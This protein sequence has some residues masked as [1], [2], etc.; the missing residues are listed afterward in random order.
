MAIKTRLG[1]LRYNNR[2]HKIFADARRLQAE[3]DFTRNVAFVRK[4]W[5]DDIKPDGAGGFYWLNVDGARFTFAT[6]DDAAND[7][8][9]ETGVTDAERASV[10]EHLTTADFA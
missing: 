1:A 5:P 10:A 7:Y 8:A 9:I 3:R 6:Y 2:M 4:H